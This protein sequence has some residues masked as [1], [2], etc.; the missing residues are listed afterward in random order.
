MTSSIKAIL[1]PTNTGKTHY[2][3]ERMMGHSSGMIGFPLRLLAREV[4]DKVVAIKGKRAVALLTGEEKILPEGARYFLCT[5]EAMPRRNDLAFAAIDEVQM[6]ADYQRGHIFTE[7][8]LH[9][10]GR[11]ETLL[12]GS[13][14]MAPI[15]RRLIPD[16][17]IVR[18][19][20]Y[21]KLSYSKPHKLSR[22]PRRSV[23]VAFSAYDVYGI[24][25]MLRRQKAGSAIVMGALSPRT[26][27]AQ[28]EMYQNGE[29]DYLVATDAIGMGLNMDIDHVAFAAMHKFDG[30]KVRNLTAA[31]LAQIAGRAGRYKKDGSF[32]TL[33]GGDGFGPLD[34][35]TIAQI[36]NHHFPAI[37]AIQWRNHKL[38]FH[39]IDKLVR[40]LEAPT[41]IEGLHRTRDSI[42]FLALK[43]LVS[44]KTI[45]DFAQNADSIHRLWD[46]C[47]IPD[48]KKLS[49]G[50]HF[51]VLRR[52]F[53]GLMGTSGVIEHDWVAKE[54][55]RLDNVEGDIDTLA[56]RI[57]NI[58]LWTYISHK[59]GWLEDAAHWA[60]VTRS[61]EDKLSDALHQGLTKRFV[62]RRIAVLMRQMRRKGELTVNIDK[63][64]IVT[65]EGELIG[66]IKGFSFIADMSADKDEQKT[67][68]AA[69]EASLSIEITRRAKIFANV[70]FKSL[71][72]NFENGLA[73]PRIAWE[74]NVIA[75]AHEQGAY[76]APRIK[77]IPE[78][79]LVGENADLVAAKTQEW[80][81]L[82]I[83]DKLAPLINLARELNGETE[84]P[85][86]AAPLSGAVRGVAYQ[87]MERYGVLPR[88]VVSEELK[89]LDN[90]ARKALRRF[91]IRI[92]STSLYIPFILKPHA[93]E[94]RLMMWAMAEKHNKLPSIP[95]PGMV[96]CETDKSAPRQ[97]YTLAGFRVVGNLSIRADMLERLADA[98]RPLGQSAGWFEV[99]PEIMGLVGVSG[100]GFAEAMAGIGYKNEVR[101]VAPSLAVTEKEDA[102]LDK[103]QAVKTEETK[104]EETSG[105]E[106]IA[107]PE[108]MD[109]L[110][111]TPVDA[112]TSDKAAVVSMNMELPEAAETN[113]IDETEQACEKT[114]EPELVER[115]FFHWQP[116]RNKTQA[117]HRPADAHRPANAG[118][119]STKSKP[120][121]NAHV[122]PP[123]KAKPPVEKPIDMD[124]PFA[125]LAALKE[126]LKKK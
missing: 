91:G 106:I 4:Y 19:E 25:E 32:T 68:N 3:V 54:V 70:G 33:G 78:T 84:T 120:V 56:S 62:D 90:E 49:D 45:I 44:D 1:G 92:G 8:L 72:L 5:A 60:H 7:H 71:E 27:N 40:S 41:N 36:E 82:R 76:L 6:A 98:V 46:V 123:I 13:D 122:K 22:L 43:A 58:R 101:K 88:E 18:R 93:T 61:V 64:D 113:K 77:L 86:G 89:A 100:E 116:K 81:D 83:A 73:T 39:S 79:M 63:S 29:V 117:T 107:V 50:E 55:K 74:G 108:A 126:Q 104:K 23:V 112:A 125:A 119:K 51:S 47:Q 105:E 26:R 24:A 10:R 28:V 75:T 9:T 80:L 118:S 99:S 111:D 14:T 2:A 103:T 48:F 121:K 115:Y 57:A 16:I 94:I 21:S 69:A 30:K 85:E 38:N 67:L 102:T 11:E 65:V 66:H 12:M 34:D 31:E 15:L 87:L 124:S 114:S 59:S 97:F 42:D 110:E 52:I 35:N 109:A 37:G 96:W 20:R 53:R 17:E 95:T